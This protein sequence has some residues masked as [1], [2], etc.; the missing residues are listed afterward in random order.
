MIII[1]FKY[2]DLINWAIPQEKINL[3]DFINIFP[4][5]LNIFRVLFITKLFNIISLINLSKLFQW[6]D[7]QSLQYIQS[8]VTSLIR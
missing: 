5:N 3:I 4:E 7:F 2:I 8:K 6:L 1:L